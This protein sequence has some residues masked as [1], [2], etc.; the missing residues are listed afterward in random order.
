M[1][2]DKAQLYLGGPAVQY[3]D[4]LVGNHAGLK[5]LKA[6]IDEAI[7]NGE[8]SVSLGDFIGVKC[9]SEEKLKEALKAENSTGSKI[10]FWLIGIC[11]LFTV[12]MVWLA[13]A[14]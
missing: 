1:K 12:V 11:F 6:A 2:D 8:S 7:E 10:G 4:A 9:L 14:Q 5:K 3:E 13:S